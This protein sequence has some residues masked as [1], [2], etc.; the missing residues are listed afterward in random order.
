MFNSLPKN[1]DGEVRESNNITHKIIPTAEELKIL[2]HKINNFKDLYI[3]NNPTYKSPSKNH[4]SSHIKTPT[5]SSLDEVKTF[6]NSHYLNI[7]E[8]E[9]ELLNHRYYEIHRYIDVNKEKVE[10]IENYDKLLIENEDL[11]N[12]IGKHKNFYLNMTYKEILSDYI[13]IK[14]EYILMH[15]QIQQQEKTIFNL[16]KQNKMLRDLDTNQNVNKNY[17]KLFLLSLLRSNGEIYETFKNELFSADSKSKLLKFLSSH[18]NSLEFQNFKMVN[19]VDSL[20]ESVTKYLN[21]LIEFSGV[22]SDIK[23]VINQVYDSQSL[24]PEFLIIRETLN[25]RS[26]FLTKQKESFILEKDKVKRIFSKEKNSDLIQCKDKIVES[27]TSSNYKEKILSEIL[28]DKIE[29]YENLKNNLLNYDEYIQKQE[30]ETNDIKENL[31]HENY[32][33]KIKN[34]KLRDAL[35]KLLENDKLNDEEHIEDINKIIHQKKDVI[36]TEDLFHILKSQ[37]LMLESNYSNI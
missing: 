29:V 37:A 21:D 35:V 34:I 5:N 16:E 8:K 33:L 3:F 17:Y 9:V 32:I 27:K 30:E 7:P 6:K 20:I 22:I 25:N 24:T 19:K 18:V 31:M 13:K 4:I 11:K 23:N 12:E 1:K 28:D 10:Q 26:N 36:F 2:R 15:D 14:S